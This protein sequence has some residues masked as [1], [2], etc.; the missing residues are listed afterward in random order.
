MELQTPRQNSVAR[1]NASPKGLATKARYRATPAGHAKDLADSAGRRAANP[2]RHRAEFKDWY[3]R[4]PPLERLLRNA[5]VSA[6]KRGLT[7]DICESDLLPLPTVCPILGIRLKYSCGGKIGPRDKSKY[8][9]ASLDRKD[10]SLGYVRGN[11]FIVSWRANQ[12]KSDATPQEIAA[13]SKWMG[14]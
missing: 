10:N 12:L 14:G 13:L 4:R 5:R 8:A 11:V 6:K 7:F 3:S 1:Y 9:Q 2:A